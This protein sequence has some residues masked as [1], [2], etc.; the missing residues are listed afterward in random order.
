MSGGAGRRARPP[1]AGVL[2]RLR[3][4]RGFIFDLDGTLVL[5]D[6]HNEGFRPLP[7]ALEFTNHLA[8][9]GVPFAIFTNGT[10]RPPGRYAE[11]LRAMGFPIEERLMLTPASIAADLFVRAAARRPPIR[12]VLVLGGEGVRA[13]LVAAGIETLLPGDGR[14]DVDA[15][16]LGAFREFRFEDLELACAAAWHGAR[17]FAASLAPFYATADGRALGTSRAIAA[18]ITSI[19]GRRASVVGKPALR[20][21]RVAAARLGLPTTALAVVGD[22]P[23]LEVPMAH[24]GR[25]L[26]VAVHTGV[27]Q[28]GAFAALAAAAKPHLAMADVAELGRWYRRG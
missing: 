26:A 27:G 3:A 13:P 9:R 15:V 16:L 10:V 25:A 23:Q 8:A 20:A 2:A 7:G 17:L 6:K 5:G 21:L 22:D 18:M 4:V 28:A 14:S 19:T 11:K 12:R 24:R 1:A